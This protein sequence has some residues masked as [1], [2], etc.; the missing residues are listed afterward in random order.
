MR[1]ALGVT[2]IGAFFCLSALILGAPPSSSPIADAASRGDDEAVRGLLQK[3]ADV[4]APQP[5][6]MTALHWA[7]YKGDA[8]M[9]E[10]LLYGGAHADAVTRIGQYTPLH[11]ASREGNTAVA[12]L[13]V[14]KGANVNAKTTNSGATALHLAAAAGNA[15]LISFL[16]DHNADVNAREDEWGQTP[17][18]FAA[19]LNRVDAIK[20]LMKRGADP[21]ITSRT[22]DLDFEAKLAQAATARQSAAIAAFIGTSGKDVELS[23]AEIQ[24]AALAGRE[25]FASRKI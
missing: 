15:E 20:V 7:A 23:P 2:L 10:M 6:G 1:S 9:A 22:V 3:G 19:S 8:E 5:D 14:E 4:N 25:V 16:L 11:I 24:A 17:L 18:I 12:K 21:S 13:L